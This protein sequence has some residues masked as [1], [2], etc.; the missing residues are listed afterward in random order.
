MA[1]TLEVE[2]LRLRGVRKLCKFLVRFRS[3][4]S[5]FCFVFGRYLLNLLVV[6]GTQCGKSLLRI[7]GQLRNTL[8]ALGSYLCKVFNGVISY[9]C[10]F[11]I[12]LSSYLCQLLFGELSYLG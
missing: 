5:K 1:G 2:K 3:D 4:E 10:D 6:V 8:I 11:K 7:S 12:T 9:L